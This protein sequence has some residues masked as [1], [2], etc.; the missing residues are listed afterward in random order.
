MPRHAF[1]AERKLSQGI[2]EERSRAVRAMG[3]RFTLPHFVQFDLGGLIGSLCTVNVN[4]F[5]PRDIH[6]LASGLLGREN[7]RRCL[8][9][10]PQKNRTISRRQQKRNEPWHD[11]NL[12]PGEAV[13]ELAKRLTLDVRRVRD[14]DS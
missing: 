4:A 1:V 5:M 12:T 10:R 14:E 8:E 2:G 13:V 11:A 6:M 7:A 3:M 9:V